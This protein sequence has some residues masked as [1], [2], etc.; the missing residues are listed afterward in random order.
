MLLSW[1]ATSYGT[2]SLSVKHAKCTKWQDNKNIPLN[3]QLYCFKRLLPKLQY[4]NINFQHFQTWYENCIV[5]TQS[6]TVIGHL[7]S[8]TPALVKNCPLN[9]HRDEKTWQVLLSSCASTPLALASAWKV[10][11]QKYNSLSI[12]SM[13]SHTL[14]SCISQ[15]TEVQTCSK[16]C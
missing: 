4:H 10:G 7:Y 9:R 15:N 13:F 11:E 5:I 6:I 2:A 16:M 3:V 8:F 14:M 1:R 12:Y